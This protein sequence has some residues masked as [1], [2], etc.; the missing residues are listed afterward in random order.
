LGIWFLTQIALGMRSTIA[1]E[2]KYISALMTHLDWSTPSTCSRHVACSRHGF[3][4]FGRSRL[5]RQGRWPP[6]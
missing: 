5:R 4:S 6:L 1:L 3:C 2:T